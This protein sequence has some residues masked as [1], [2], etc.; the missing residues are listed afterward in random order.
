MFQLQGEVDQFDR[1]TCV[2]IW[3]QTDKGIDWVVDHDEPPD[4]YSSEDI[5]EYILRQYVL[6]AAET[7]SN[8]RIR[9]YLDRAE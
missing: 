7:Y 5:V 8:A 2:A 3:C 4:T 9:K 1:W 6:P